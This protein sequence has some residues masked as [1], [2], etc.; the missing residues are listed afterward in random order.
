MN[1]G[2]RVVGSLSLVG[3][4]LAGTTPG[5]AGQVDVPAVSLRASAADTAGNTVQQTI[6]RAYRLA[7]GD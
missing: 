5:L 3:V 6:T 4:L 7:L 1:V 2:T